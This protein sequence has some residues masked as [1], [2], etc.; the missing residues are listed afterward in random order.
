[1]PIPVV[2]RS[3][4]QQELQYD[5]NTQ[6]QNSPQTIMNSKLS[7]T[8][9]VA[10]PW[11]FVCALIL[12]GGLLFTENLPAMPRGPLPPIPEAQSICH[13][14]FDEDFSWGATATSLTIPNFGIFD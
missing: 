9:C 5:S 6:H 12:A 2:V 3:N 11:S 1:M 14:S 7:N 10:L 8:F 4:F 13:E